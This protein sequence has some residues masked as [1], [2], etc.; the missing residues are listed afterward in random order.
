AFF[1]RPRPQSAIFFE[2][3]FSFPSGHSAIAIAF[4]GFIAYVL[5]RTRTGKRKKFAIFILSF[6]LM[7]LIGFSRAYLGLHYFSDIIGGYLLGFLWLI[8]AISIFEWAQ[9]KYKVQNFPNFKLAKKTKKIIF[10]LLITQLFFYIG[11]SLIYRQQL[12]FKVP[13]QQAVTTDKILDPFFRNKITQYSETLSGKNQEPMS[14]LIIAQ[15]DIQLEDFFKKS[16]WF[17]ADYFNRYSVARMIVA[18]LLDQSYPTNVITPSFWNNRVHDFGFQK[19]SKRN[20][21]K[22]RH[23]VRF[24]KTNIYTRD[25]KRLYVG[26]A[27]Y[28]TDIKWYITHKI[29]PNIDKEREYLFKDLLK[30][31]LIKS[32]QKIQFVKPTKGKNF[33][34]D[35]FFTDGK[36]YLINLK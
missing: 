27:S 32:Y 20:S 24:W 33:T 26:T 12:N 4:Y 13:V 17:A 34:G 1:N 22:E 8:I 7:F 30:S 29:D 18:G 25:G 36:A 16:G 15:S 2:N 10:V 6:L 35:A 9:Y 28:D 31:G 21:I 19:P 3:S 14:F 5:L 23:H 11:F